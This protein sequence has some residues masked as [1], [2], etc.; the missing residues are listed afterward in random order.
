M[1]TF[2]KYCAALVFLL[3]ALVVVVHHTDFE[4][5]MRKIHGSC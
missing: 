5:L 3:A 1:K 2:F 4:G